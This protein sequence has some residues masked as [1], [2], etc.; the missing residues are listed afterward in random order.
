MPEAYNTFLLVEVQS[1][2]AFCFLQ[3]LI[4]QKAAEDLKKKQEAEAA[5]K[6][7]AVEARVGKLNIDGMGPGPTLEIDQMALWHDTTGL[8]LLSLNWYSQI[9]VWTWQFH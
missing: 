8:N 6:K 4:M 7:A 9:Y 5:E 3:Q 2:N 1:L